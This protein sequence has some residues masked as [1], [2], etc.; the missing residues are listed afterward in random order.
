MINIPNFDDLK[1]GLSLPDTFV[2]ANRLNTFCLDETTDEVEPVEVAR[3]RD[4]L[5]PL[6]AVL[7]NQTDEP[8]NKK[9]AETAKLVR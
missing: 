4:E 9:A 8:D 1:K 3:F 7:W 6:V 2:K 5:Q